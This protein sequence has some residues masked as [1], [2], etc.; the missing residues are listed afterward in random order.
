MLG[1]VSDSVSESYD[2]EG[3]NV[4]HR[5]LNSI[6]T[7]CMLLR[8]GSIMTACMLLRLGSEMNVSAA[9]RL[10]AVTML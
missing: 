9:P 1:S 3:T 4:I 5:C 7:A 6:M 2:V 10:K 8:L